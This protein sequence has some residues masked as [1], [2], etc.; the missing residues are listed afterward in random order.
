VARAAR[1]RLVFVHSSDELYG[2]DRILLDVHDALPDRLR[3]RAVFW[4][5]TDVPHGPTRL[6]TELER[7]GAVVRHL[8]LPVLRRSYRTPRALAGLA[9]RWVRLVGELRRARPALVYCSTSAVLTAAPA[10]R[11]AGVPRVVGHVQEIWTPGDARV[12]GPLG[13]AC[14]TLVAI[15]G[16]VHEAL[17]ARLRERAAVVANATPEPGR[18]VPLEGRRGPLRFVVAS[19]W[20]AWKG[21]R[22]LLAAWDRLDSPGE[23]VVLGGPPPSGEATDVL[24]LATAL[25]HP[26]SVRVVGEVPDPHAYVEDADVV[27]VPSDQPEPFGLVAVEAFARGRPVVASAGG[28]LADIVTEGRDGWLFPPGDVEALARVLARLDRDQ[29]AAAG[30]RARATYERRYTADRYAEQWR[31]AVDL[32]GPGWGPR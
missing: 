12:L 8:D 15:S 4:L 14:R 18:V 26:G 3:D 29:V 10:A 24:A 22:T 27:V 25:R 1:D 30:R 7:R 32:P 28:G 16:P 20:N 11:L 23:L 6:C 2:A 19:R 9:R 17:P 5:P 31:R 21:H 13:R